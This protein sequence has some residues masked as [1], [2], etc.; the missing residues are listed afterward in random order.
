MGKLDLEKLMKGAS[1][2]YKVFPR[3]SNNYIFL[4]I[5]DIYTVSPVP[6]QV[7]DFVEGARACELRGHSLNP[8]DENGTFEVE[9]VRLKPEYSAFVG[10][11]FERDAK[12]IHFVFLEVRKN[13]SSEYVFYRTVYF[14]TLQKYSKY[15]AEGFIKLLN[16]ITS[17]PLADRSKR[18]LYE[19]KVIPTVVMTTIHSL[20]NFPSPDVEVVEDSRWSSDVIKALEEASNM[21]KEIGKDPVEVLSNAWLGDYFV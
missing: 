10:I 21:L 12:L 20:L 5:K 18:M 6:W 8:F 16:N 3:P 9:L 17:N 4:S 2:L 19:L 7:K 1:F 15:S 14:D 11:N 13:I